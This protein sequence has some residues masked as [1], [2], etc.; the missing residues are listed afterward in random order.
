[1]MSRKEEKY[2]RPVTSSASKVKEPKESE[3][4]LEKKKESGMNYTQYKSKNAAKRPMSGSKN[5]KQVRKVA[6][7]NKK[8]TAF[9][10]QKEG[11]I[12]ATNVKSKFVFENIL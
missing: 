2:H 3:K 7:F 10:N 9:L 12:W 5:W 11:L 6:S 1:M 4:I 8:L